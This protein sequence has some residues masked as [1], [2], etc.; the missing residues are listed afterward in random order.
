MK[1]ERRERWVKEISKLNVALSII[2]AL[3]EIG[4][5]LS[6]IKNAITLETTVMFGL[7]VALVFL[8][9]D[10]VRKRKIVRMCKTE[11]IL[12]KN[13]PAIV[14][15]MKARQSLPK[16]FKTDEQ[17]SYNMMKATYEIV[18]S[19]ATYTKQE[20]GQ[21]VSKNDLEK[22]VYI[23]CGETSVSNGSVK[24][25]A[26]RKLKRNE[27]EELEPSVLWAT[28]TVKVVGVD[29]NPPVK[30]A[31]GK[32]DITFSTKWPGAFVSK[33]G[34]VFVSPLHCTRG[35]E[36]LEVE[37][38]FQERISQCSVW[39]WDTEKLELEELE[40][41]ENPKRR[42][43]KYTLKWQRAHP[44]VRRIYIFRYKRSGKHLV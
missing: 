17:I 24:P 40:K 7:V 42:K 21:N 9:Q 13:F 38:V 12:S 44:D 19:D 35:L 5:F 23:F 25:Q 43:N 20:I 28:S 8:I 1:P 33:Y 29:L 34:Y 10:F 39:T 22:M 27:K 16:E 26:F 2:A 32:I 6:Y 15:F 4:L 41:L 11:R 37:V 31:T 30:P 18:R 3:I 36:Q 14:L